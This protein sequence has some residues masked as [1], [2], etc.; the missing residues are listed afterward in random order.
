MLLLFQIPSKPNY[1]LVFYYAADRPVKKSSLLGKFIDGTDTFRDSRFKLIPS[2]V[3][4]Y[5]IGSPYSA[6]VA[7]RYMFSEFAKF[8]YYDFMMHNTQKLTA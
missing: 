4:V 7:T 8:I 1:N 6:S 3:K 5:T 2:I